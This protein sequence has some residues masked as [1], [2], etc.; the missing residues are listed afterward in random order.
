MNYRH[1]FHAGSPADV[2]KHAVLTRIL[3]HLR[4]KPA[5]FRVIDTHAGAGLYDLRGPEAQRSPEWREGIERLLA[6]P[7]D[8]GGRALLAPYLDIV[9]G[10]NPAFNSTG[11]LAAYPGSPALARALMRTQ[12]RLVA[13]EAEPNAAAAL[14]RNL[15][16]D[17]RIKAI[18]ID[19]WVALNA[20]VPPPERRGV[21]L[22][23]PPFEATGEFDRLA[24]AM[25]AAHRKWSTGIFL[26]WYPI[27]GRQEPDAFVRRLQRSA[28]PKVLRAEVEFD[29]SRAPA[30]LGGCGMIVVN[31]P[32]MLDDELRILLEAFA[33]LFARSH[34]L[35]WVAAGP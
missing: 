15:G 2:V 8:A 13:C 21:V 34:R 29:G 32:W 6:M 10:L 23:D 1:A 25:E 3:V 12:D 9:A 4:N 31:P 14:T 7:I 26:A 19:G 18:A 30:R 5:G 11:E 16:R 35:D 22:I 28:I 33:K 20:Y 17:R 27:K 24:H